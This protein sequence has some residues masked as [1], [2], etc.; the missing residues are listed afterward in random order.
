LNLSKVAEAQTKQSG[1]YALLIG[2]Y[3]MVPDVISALKNAATI[4]KIP[5]DVLHAVAITESDLNPN[6]KSKAGAMGLMQIMPVVAKNFGVKDPFDPNENALAGA[7]LLKSYLRQLHRDWILALAAYNWGKRN[8]DKHP[9]FE[10][11]PTE[12]KKYVKKVMGLSKS[13]F[14]VY[15]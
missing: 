13:Y 15:I 11:W 8:I 1:C 6:A 4:T 5:F 10:E 12:T 3:Q 7:K 9:N 14:A 2:D